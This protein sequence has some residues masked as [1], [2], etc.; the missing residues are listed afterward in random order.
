MLRITLGNNPHKIKR[1]KDR[2]QQRPP[3]QLPRPLE[4]RLAVRRQVDFV[5][6][7]QVLR[8]R[9]D[10]ECIRADQHRQDFKHI[11]QRLVAV[12]VAVVGVEVC[13]CA[14]CVSEEDEERRGVEFV[15]DG[16][17]VAGEEAAG[18]AAA[19][20]VD[21]EGDEGEEHDELEDEAGLDEFLADLDVGGRAVAVGDDGDAVGGDGFDDAVEAEEGGEDAPGVDY[22]EVGHLSSG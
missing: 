20:E 6:L 18:D 11:E 8:R 21:D 17:D 15:D 12:G 19:V 7:R 5:V 10:V 9:E 3:V 22:G 16:L 4:L 2:Q 1:I 13:R 14:E